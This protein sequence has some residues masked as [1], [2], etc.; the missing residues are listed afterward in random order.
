MKKKIKVKKVRKKGIM[1][2]LMAS[3]GGFITFVIAINIYF[4]I[5][6]INSAVRTLTYSANDRVQGFS[7]GIEEELKNGISG[8]NSDINLLVEDIKSQVKDENEI[9]KIDENKVEI[10]NKNMALYGKVYNYM[11]EKRFELVADFEKQRDEAIRRAEIVLGIIG[12]GVIL[13]SLLIAGIISRYIASPVK[14][15]G[16]VVKSISEEDG[17]L[18]IRAEIVSNDEIGFMAGYLNNFIE[19]IYIVIINVKSIIKEIKEKNDEFKAD[20]EKIINGEVK[21]NY[22]FEGMVQLDYHMEKILENSEEQ[23]EIT[24][25]SIGNINEII[26]KNSEMKI[27]MDDNT[28][29]AREAVEIAENGYEEIKKLD[30][31]IESIEKEALNTSDK[32]SEFLNL[33][34]DIDM[35]AKVIR[36]IADQTHLLALNAAIEAA[37][38]GDAGKGFAVV[39][40]HIR[41]LAEKTN[42]ETEK[43]KDI[44]SGITTEIREIE[45]ANGNVKQTIAEGIE[46]SEKVREEII[47]IIEKSKKNDI[48]VQ[49]ISE[50][51]DEQAEYCEKV[52]EKSEMIIENSESIKKHIE[53]TTVISKEIVEMLLTR[54]EILR[55]NSEIIDKLK[56]KIEFFKT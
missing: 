36:E 5:S 38:A 32:I 51:I 39:A 33:S 48:N 37:R 45:S 46:I 11:D 9:E 41:V 17:N 7:S 42:E 12:I 2:K 6:Y 23:L 20:M 40:E 1:F 21:E 50:I 53:D 52:A 28:T 8:T 19:K 31:K 43:I 27:K 13:L 35:I 22:H 49:L 29:G 15:I 24:E 16:K 10:L 34:N 47:K 25:F 3:F 18:K 44:T 30:K 14:K 26:N 56:S 54:S 4:S 55:N